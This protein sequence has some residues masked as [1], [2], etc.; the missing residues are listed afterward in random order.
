MLTDDEVVHDA[1]VRHE[2]HILETR[3]KQLA[4][5]RTGLRVQTAEVHDISTGAADFC[6]HRAEVFF[7]SGQAF[8]Q[9]GFHAALGQLCTGVRG[10][11]STS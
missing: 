10:L 5:Q 9:D 7:T 11:P 4:D 6:H 8:F 1:I 3:L 2:F